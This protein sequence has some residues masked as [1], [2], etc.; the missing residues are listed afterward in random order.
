MDDIAPI[1]SGDDLSIAMVGRSARVQ[2]QSA[3]IILGTVCDRAVGCRWIDTTFTAY[4]GCDVVGA[5]HEAGVWCLLAHRDRSLVLVEAGDEHL[6]HRVVSVL[7]RTLYMT[8]LVRTPVDVPTCLASV[9]LV[10]VKV[11]ALR[12]VLPADRDKKVSS[13]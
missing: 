3:D 9:C 7:A 5:L 6:S 13:P 2:L 1:V 4:P 11:T 10:P 12:D 8:A